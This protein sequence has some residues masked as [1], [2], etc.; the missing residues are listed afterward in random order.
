MLTIAIPDVEILAARWFTK[1][2]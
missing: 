1:C 2:S